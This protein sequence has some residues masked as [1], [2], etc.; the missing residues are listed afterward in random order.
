M[1]K[2][3]ITLGVL[4]GLVVAASRAEAAPYDFSAGSWVIPM[5]SCYQPSQPFQNSGT[6]SGTDDPSTVYGA[7]SNCP[8]TS[9]TAYDGVLK[10]YGFVY[11]LL[12]N[13]VPVY[14]ILD[15]NKTSVDAADLTLTGANVVKLVN[16]STFATTNF[17][18]PTTITYRG[19]PFIIAAGDVPA[20]KALM[21]SNTSFTQTDSRTGR[22]M[23]ADVY[24]HEA[25]SNILQAPVRALLL[26]TPPKIALLNIG[27]AA[28]G[29]LIGYLLDSGLYDAGAVAA[30]PTIGSI[31]TEFNSP[32]NFTTQNGLVAGGFSILWSP[33][34]QA[35]DITL[36]TQADR[37]AIT[38]KISQFLDAGHHFLAQCASV[39]AIEG[40]NDGAA[41]WQGAPIAPDMVG[42][43]NGFFLTNG[44]GTAKSLITNQVH[45]SDFPHGGVGSI[46]VNPNATVKAWTDP[47]AQTG[48]FTLA[49][50]ATTGHNAFVFD[51]K[52]DSGFAY[53]SYMNTYVQTASTGNNATNGLSIETV[54]YKDGDTSKGLVIYLG[55]HS[56]GSKRDGCNGGI[57]NPQN[58]YEMIGLERLVLNSLIF[59]G[60]QPQ[61]K[62][63]TRSAPIV[64]S[65]GK[66]YLGTY[67]QQSA[68]TAGYPP[69]QG[70]FREYASGALSGSNVTAFSSI[71]S[72]W[73][74]YDRV[75]IQAAA[76]NGTTNTN[77][78]ARAIYT[79]VP[80]SGKLTKIDF[81]T[82]NLAKVQLT[83]PTATTTQITQIRQGLLGGVDHSIPAIIPASDIAGS[84][85]RATMAYFGALD[86]MIH[87]IVISGTVNGHTAG[88]EAWAFIPPSQLAKTFAQSG[89]VD[90]SPS[91]GDAFIDTSGTGNSH[92]WHTLLAIP[93]NGYAGGTL[94]VLDVTDPANPLFLWEASDSTTIGGKTYVM[95]RAQ[96]AAIAPVM[97]TSGVKFAYFMVTDNTTGTAGNAWNAY[98]INAE[99]GTVIWRAQHLYAYDTTHND[100][101]GTIA[102][103][104]DVGDGGPVNKV[105]FADLEGHVWR[106]SAIDGSG[107]TSVF[108]APTLYA[109]ASSINYPIESGISLYR[110][111]TNQ[112]LSALGVTSGADWVPAATLSKVF[113]IDLAA[114]PSPTSTTLTT[115]ASGERVYA[116]PTISGNNAYFI[117]SN[118]N[119]QSAIG[120]SFTATGNLMRVDLGNTPSVS[121][122]A[123]VKQGAAQVA[124]DASGNV[125]AVSAT[126][127]TQ[128]GNSGVDNS[129]STAALQNL[130]AKPIQVRAW[131]DLH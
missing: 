88:Q 66:T 131:L 48:D 25:Q 109:T 39:A 38:L 34:W 117:T 113:K 8:D 77:T 85:S 12:Q 55:G 82:G 44:T 116:V 76:D 95:G 47:L 100:V 107:A 27:N 20:V 9:G 4:F 37:D 43:T 52:A 33:H 112:H 124:V 45:Q 14:Y 125:I 63:Q 7:H 120:N 57:C 60:Q 119:L 29:V 62:E 118:G 84:S 96:G 92:S 72:N 11:R 53:E 102:V 42:N 121:T 86:G 54:G 17:L 69:W 128:N 68:A 71:V 126:G 114:T 94:D 103:I 49:N 89:G 19:A 36:T 74:S 59:L 98:A 61:S 1:R 106:V 105:Y 2:L 127:I 26:Q 23:F 32:S 31:F 65:D 97:T 81:T 130:A 15:T 111:P 56:Y 79:A 51:F 123:T 22:G 40:S 28:I 64:F 58:Q 73:D 6:F 70:H 90:G 101:P 115:L 13:G 50:T 83:V 104:D 91:V 87:A 80:Q 129:Q 16:H 21:T 3:G 110:D 30:Y 5:D 35:D 75:K 78:A 41:I 18:S 122:L 93:D 24:I 46:V 108:D 67:V 99:D 10:A